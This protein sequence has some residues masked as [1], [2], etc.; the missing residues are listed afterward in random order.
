[1][2]P[3]RYRKLVAT[4]HSRDFRAVAKV[5]EVPME[6]PGPGQVLIQNRFAGVNAS[7]VNCAP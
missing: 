1:M 3:A 7:D 4:G 2:L 6:A 5:V